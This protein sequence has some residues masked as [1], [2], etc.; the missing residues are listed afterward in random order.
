MAA[1]SAVS[2][3]SPPK[4]FFGRLFLSH[5]GARSISNARKLEFERLV[6]RCQKI[7][8]RNARYIRIS[9]DFFIRD[10]YRDSKDSARDEFILRSYR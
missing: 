10:A 3:K 8:N 9:P 4:T 7:V 1:R 6:K 2:H 5:S